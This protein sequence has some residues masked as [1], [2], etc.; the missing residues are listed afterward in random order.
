MQQAHDLHKAE[1]ERGAKVR[2]EVEPA[3]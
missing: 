2:A 1:T 3:A